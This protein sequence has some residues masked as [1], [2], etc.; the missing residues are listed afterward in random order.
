LGNWAF[1]NY[2]IYFSIVVSVLSLGVKVGVRTT[3]NYEDYAVSRE[4][5]R[6][7]RSVKTQNSK[8]WNV[9]KILEILKLFLNRLKSFLDFRS[10]FKF[11]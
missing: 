9:A 6:L 8:F 10:G 7:L 3:S 4:C 2:V 11:I 5:I 1:D